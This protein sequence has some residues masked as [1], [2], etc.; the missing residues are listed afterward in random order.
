MPSIKAA[1]KEF[2]VSKNTIM[3]AY[4]HLEHRG[5]LASRERSGF[6]ITYFS[7][8]DSSSPDR[9]PIYPGL[10]FSA[11]DKRIFHDSHKLGSSIIANFVS[12]NRHKSLMPVNQLQ[13]AMRNAQTNMLQDCLSVTFSA[14]HQK[15]REALTSHYHQQGLE[16]GSNEIFITNGC[17]EAML[18]SLMTITNVGDIV[19]VESPTHTINIRLV[20]SLGRTVLE[21]PSSPDTGV[22]LKH[23]ANAIDNW[24]IKACLFSGNLSSP[25]GATMP[26]SN[27]KRLL[28][29]LKEHRIPLIENDVHGQL[30]F[31]NRHLPAIKE[32]DSDGMVFYCS[33]VSKSLSSGL[34]VGWCVPPAQYRAQYM[35]QR[36]IYAPVLPNFGQLVV[37]DMIES[38]AYA[39]HLKRLQ[40]EL[41]LSH[42]EMHK[43]IRDQFPKGTEHTSPE[44]GYLTWVKLPQGISA[45]TL[46]EKAYE[47]GVLIVPGDVY[48]LSGSHSDHFRL[49]VAVPREQIRIGLSILGCIASSL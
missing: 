6:F 8:A 19:A 13:T 42:A 38:R 27:K 7:P 26:D 34:R 39:H 12:F 49:S 3:S 14:G 35:E 25:T 30:G 36:S 18:I 31:N 1:M 15:L 45:W 47:Q 21:I 48:S 9:K 46:Y 37:A 20:M 44:G 22:N 4:H 10:H 2:A 29:I 17:R 43:I 16:F 32:F 40:R 33:S 41:A 11:R 5:Y 28:E 23:L 24:D